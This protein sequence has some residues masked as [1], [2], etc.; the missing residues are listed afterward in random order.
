MLENF[1]YNLGR[2][3]EFYEIILLGQRSKGGTA[4][5]VKK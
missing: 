1:K 3:Y 5:A 4:I 2:E